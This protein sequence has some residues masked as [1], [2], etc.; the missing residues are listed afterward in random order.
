M[1]GT[2]DT[3]TD[4]NR[5][6]KQ[7]TGGNYNLWGEY[8]N[9]NFDLIDDLK[10]GNLILTLSTSQHTLTVND[11]AADEARMASITVI[12]T[13]GGTGTIT[14][15][16]VEKLTFVENLVA[17]GY[18]L[19]WTNGTGTAA[20]V[21]NGAAVMMQCDFAGN[22][23]ILGGSQLSGRILRKIGQG[24]ASDDAVRVDQ[25]SAL[26]R[27]IPLGGTTGQFPQ[28]AGYGTNTDHTLTTATWATGALVPAD[29]TDGMI[30][31]SDSGT[32]SW[33][34]PVDTNLLVQGH[35][36]LY[37]P[38]AA[39]T[40]LSTG[41]GTAT[42]IMCTTSSK[43]VK[44][45]VFGSASSQYVSFDAQMPKSWD[46]MNLL[47]SFNAFTTGA[48][49]TAVFEMSIGLAQTYDGVT[50]DRAFNY[51]DGI[52]GTEHGTASFVSVTGTATASISGGTAAL[53]A[54]LSVMARRKI[55]GSDNMSGNLF[56]T[57]C[58]VRYNNN[59]PNDD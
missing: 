44:A 26:T 52:L 30:L 13:P 29:G 47:A 11:G 49:G 56:V 35:E 10:D 22:M 5:L 27:G 9:D 43:M 34:D 7:P 55:G 54:I 53:G 14:A 41:G 37:I 24:T 8:L 51:H 15:P 20:T 42:S 31:V 25:V 32:G 17:G 46:G 40:P 12:G 4:S 6:D 38:A 28:N 21:Y 57:G 16:N 39:F 18:P 36:T 2:S 59:L 48:T 45:I 58:T 23:K 33:T 19:V 1:P 50:I 3:F